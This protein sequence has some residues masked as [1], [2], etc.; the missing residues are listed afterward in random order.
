MKIRPIL[1]LQEQ[2]VGKVHGY[3]TFQYDIG[4]KTRSRSCI[5]NK[6]VYQPELLN[7]VKCLREIKLKLN[8]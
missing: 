3:Q 7:Y 6:I 2:N 4:K 8:L 1:L 5:I